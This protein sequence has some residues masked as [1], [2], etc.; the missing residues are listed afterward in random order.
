MLNPFLLLSIFT[1]TSVCVCVYVYVC[2]CGGWGG[3]FRER[4]SL[5]QNL[6]SKVEWGGG[7]TMEGA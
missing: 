6:T 5:I 4:K 1:L 7:A 3:D 2:V